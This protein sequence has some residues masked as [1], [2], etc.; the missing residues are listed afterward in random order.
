MIWPSATTGRPATIVSR[1]DNGPHRSHASIGS[2]SA[3]ANA[4]PPSPQTTRS[5][6]APGDS[7]PISPA[8]PRQP[9]LPRVA[10]SRTSRAEKY[11]E[12]ACPASS[13][14]SPALPLRSPCSALRCR[15]PSRS[16][17]TSRALRASVHIDAES[18]LAEP[19]TPRPTGTPAARSSRTG[20][21]PT[22]SSRLELGQCATPVPQEP[23]CAISAGLGCTPCAIH[24]RSE[25]Q[26]QCSKYSTGRMP[27]IS[28]QNPS[29]PG[30][31]ARCVCNRT[32]RRSASSAVAVIRSVETEN[33]EH[34]ANAIRTIAFGERS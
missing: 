33:G 4:G 32:S 12:S 22:P 16:R 17:P 14:P 5:P 25:P 10:R 29:S 31:S 24:E 21:S 26:P 13:L 15:W 20:A 11:T 8:R 18:V 23:S 9:A 1:A 34:G 3:P 27:N 6:H 2:D 19:S 30:S 28:R 7:S